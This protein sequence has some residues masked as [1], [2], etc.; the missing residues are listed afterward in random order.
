MIAAYYNIKTNKGELKYFKDLFLIY[1]RKLKQN[2]VSDIMGRNAASNTNIFREYII[3]GLQ[4]RQ[5]KWVEMVIKRYSPMLPEYIREDEYILAL[6]RL[7]FAKKEYEKVIKIIDRNTIKN[8][9]HQLDSKKKKLA[10]Y[11]ELKKYEECYSEIDKAKHFLK[12]NK[13]KT[14]EV[15]L[16]NFK[17]FID[18]FLKL[19]NYRT[20]PFNKDA[21]SVLR[22]IDKPNSPMKGWINKKLKEIVKS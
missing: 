11:Y 2:L 9:T 6:V 19:L 1:K 22:N 21:Y 10:S 5:Y 18:I 7:H 15:I 14:P 8:I 20:N 3:A 4:V 16:K 12:N 17:N 13:T